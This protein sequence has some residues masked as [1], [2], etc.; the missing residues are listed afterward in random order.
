MASR[1]GEINEGQVIIEP[2]DAMVTTTATQVKTV[3]AGAL[4]RQRFY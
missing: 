1:A 3:T 2:I 4:L